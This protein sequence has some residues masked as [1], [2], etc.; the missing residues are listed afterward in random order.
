[1]DKLGIKIPVLAFFLAIVYFASDGFNVIDAVIRSFML[2]FGIALIILVL[3]MVLI[4]FLTLQKNR[5]D[6]REILRAKEPDLAGHA[7]EKKAEMQ[8]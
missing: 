6:N 4:F 1:M 3:T 8:T 7:R 2:A 5:Y